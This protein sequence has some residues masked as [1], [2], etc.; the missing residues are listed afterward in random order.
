MKRQLRNPALWV[1][2]IIAGV[3]LQANAADPEQDQLRKLDEHSAKGLHIECHPTKRHFVIGE[4]VNLQC[5]LTNTT[6]SIKRI[7]SYPAVEM[8]FYCAKDEASWGNGFYPQV[9]PQ[10]RPPMRVE[11]MAI[12]LPPHTSLE[13]LLSH[14]PDRSKS[15]GGIVVYDPDIHGGGFWGNDA[16]EKAKRACI[17]SNRFEYEVG[18]AE[19]K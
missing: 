4:P 17:F 6:D 2:P 13:L 16:L 1:I 15:F 12:L 11:H 14:K 10:I 9:T 8:H 7:A 5:V 19:K 3:A 18:A